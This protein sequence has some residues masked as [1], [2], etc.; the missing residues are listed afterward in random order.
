[1]GLL[2]IS[3]RRCSDV[4]DSK[5]I[6]RPSRT[7]RKIK[8]VTAETVCE[9]TA[10]ADV[11]STSFGKLLK[12]TFLFAATALATAAQAAEVTGDMALAAAR[13]WAAQNRSLS[14]E[15]GG[16][17]SVKERRDDDGTLLWYE[18]AMSGGG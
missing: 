3:R 10:C 2:L 13:A 15:I 9:R 12:R 16:P 1:M 11:T 8:T 17:V 4:G 18:V 6:I 5:R 14:G 7:L